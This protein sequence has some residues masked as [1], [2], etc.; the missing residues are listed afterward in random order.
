MEVHEPGDR[1]ALP[2]PATQRTLARMMRMLRE[3]EAVVDGRFPSRDAGE[4]PC[5]HSEELRLRVSQ[6]ALAA[7]DAARQ[8]GLGVEEATDAVA[9]AVKK[10]V[11]T[12]ASGLAG[13][14]AASGAAGAAAVE[15]ARLTGFGA[16]VAAIDCRDAPYGEYDAQSGTL[17]L[18]LP[19]R[20]GGTSGEGF[21][22]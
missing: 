18:N 5:L 2:R 22:P 16:R 7:S 12:G 8:A 13:P 3:L 19:F 9:R 4:Q 6:I 20:S 17:V 10:A 11:A 15:L 1:E 21:L 14:E